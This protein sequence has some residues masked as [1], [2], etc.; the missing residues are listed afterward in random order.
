MGPTLEFSTSPCSPCA[1]CSVWPR[2]RSSTSG[3]SSSPRS[4]SS[5]S[6]PR[7]SCSEM[8]AKTIWT[9]RDILKMFVIKTTTNGSLIHQTDRKKP[10]LSGQ[11]LLPK[12]DLN[13]FN[14]CSQFHPLGMIIYLYLYSFFCFVLMLLYM[15]VL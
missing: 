11:P 9:S 7:L 4:S 13:F 1:V 12:L 2:G 8:L 3:S 6:P 15:S 14:H 10:I 5:K